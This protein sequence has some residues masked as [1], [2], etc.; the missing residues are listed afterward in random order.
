MFE[1]KL[2]I[3]SLTEEEKIKYSKIGGKKA[4][5]IMNSQKWKCLI[6]GHITNPGAL[7]KYQRARGI[8]ISLREK[9]S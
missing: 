5:K 1:E 9:V 7:T 3:F 8:D 4:A 2:G 6:T